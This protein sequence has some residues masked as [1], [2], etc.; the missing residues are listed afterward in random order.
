MGLGVLGTGLDHIGAISQY[1]QHSV[2]R[3]DEFEA[4]SQTTKVV[5]MI[6]PVD[7]SVDKMDH[8]MTNNYRTQCFIIADS[9]V[10]MT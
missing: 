4:N 2:M 3:K 7:Y 5:F 1:L 8:D 10:S 6:S 9:S